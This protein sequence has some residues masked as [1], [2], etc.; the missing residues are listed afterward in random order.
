M[1]APA[2][3]T[4]RL[5][6][7]DLKAG[8]GG[9]GALRFTDVTAR[10]GIGFRAYGM[11]AAVADY[12]NDGDPDL[13]LTSF[14]PD[15]LYRNNGDG[16][17]TDVTAA[18]GVSDPLWSTSAAFLDYDRDGDLDLFV[19]N[20]LDFAVTDNKVC[21]DALGSRDYCGPRTFTAALSPPAVRA[22]RRSAGRPP[23]SPRRRTGF[24]PVAAWSAK[25][26]PHR[27]RKRRAPVR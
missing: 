7:N 6:R 10:A 27:L 8:S 25:A 9:R 24:C 16:T 14:G 15:A 5:F 2:S 4:S 11:G 21:A 1:S 20:Y 22:I 23:Y 12:D 18:A 19:A 17:F 26:L 3:G 13:F